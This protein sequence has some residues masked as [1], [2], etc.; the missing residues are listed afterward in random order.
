MNRKEAIIEIVSRITR[1]IENAI[2]SSEEPIMIPKTT[3]I[4]PNTNNP[5]EPL[6][7]TILSN[8]LKVDCVPQLFTDL[9]LQSSCILVYLLISRSFSGYLSGNVGIMDIIR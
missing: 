1:I 6:W 5:P 8:E 4:I 7:L 9:A 3:G 2:L